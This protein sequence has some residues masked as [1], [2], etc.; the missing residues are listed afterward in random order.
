[1][2]KSYATPIKEAPKEEEKTPEHRR[3]LVPNLV[4]SNLSKESER[5]PNHK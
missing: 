1:M 5:T 4:L 2:K 3:D